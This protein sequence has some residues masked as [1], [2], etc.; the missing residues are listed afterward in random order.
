MLK[1]ELELLLEDFRLSVESKLD[2]L[3][4]SYIAKY[5]QIKHET[6]ELRRIRKQFIQPNH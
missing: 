2:C 1:R 5:D 3:Y 6:K 4:R